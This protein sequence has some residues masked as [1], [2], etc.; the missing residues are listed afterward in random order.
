MHTA[1][2]PIDIT[3]IESATGNAITLI[4]KRFSFSMKKGCIM[5]TKKVLFAIIEIPPESVKRRGSSKCLKNTNTAALIIN[6]LI[7]LGLNQR[8]S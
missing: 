5:Y 2:I 6:T 1:K 8:S 7:L 4:P 3:G